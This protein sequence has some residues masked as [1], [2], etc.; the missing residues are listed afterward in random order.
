MT[1][2]GL[3]YVLLV[4]ALGVELYTIL[5]LFPITSIPSYSVVMLFNP[6]LKL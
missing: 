5:V 1:S 2:V 6:L 3:S 4:D